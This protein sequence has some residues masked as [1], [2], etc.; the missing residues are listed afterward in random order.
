MYTYCDA[1]GFAPVLPR[2]NIAPT[3]LH[4][5]KDVPE[6]PIASRFW[7]GYSTHLLFSIGHQYS[8]STAVKKCDPMAGDSTSL[9]QRESMYLPYRFGIRTLRFSAGLKLF[10]PAQILTIID[11]RLPIP[12][13][14]PHFART[15]SEWSLKN[16]ARSVCPSMPLEFMK[17]GRPG[18]SS[19]Q[20]P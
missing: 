18:K 16:R 7:A 17:V 4:K 11:S 19:P 3:F 6:R 10:I 14:A 9:C 13:S 2:V 20:S 1:A 12:I 5:G 15:T 8:L